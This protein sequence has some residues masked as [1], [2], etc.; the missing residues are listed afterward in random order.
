MADYDLPAI[1]SYVLQVTRQ[2]QLFYVGNSQ[3]TLIALNGFSNNLALGDNVK[4]FFTLTSVYTL[5]DTTKN[6]KGFAEI[7]F[8]PG[9]Y[10]LI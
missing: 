6:A 10:S 7:M 4:A 1:I 8:S 3:G 5:N 2:K 9:G